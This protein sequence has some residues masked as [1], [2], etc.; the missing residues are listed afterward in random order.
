MS[1]MH[2]P[3]YVDSTDTF[4]SATCVKT[5]CGI[6]A[7]STSTPPTTTSPGQP[8]TLQN[9]AFGSQTHPPFAQSPHLHLPEQ[10]TRMT[11]PGHGHPQHMLEGTADL[12][13]RSNVSPETVRSST[14]PSPVSLASTS[15]IPEHLDTARKSQAPRLQA[16]PPY[17]TLQSPD[18]SMSGYISTS[19]SP[20][21]MQQHHHQPMYAYHSMSIRCK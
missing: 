7:R 8:Q 1:T 21:Y 9:Q 17:Q 11:H 3:T 6:S 14:D 10:M 13:A 12:T 16:S 2:Q 18:P 20:N 4:C 15:I 5:K 19:S